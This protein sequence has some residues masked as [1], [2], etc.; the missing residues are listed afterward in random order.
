M[1]TTTGPTPG[2]TGAGDD[3]PGSP[4]R[5]RAPLT[6]AAAPAA[7]VPARV[8]G[9][10]TGRPLVHRAVGA[11]PAVVAHRGSSLAHPENTLPALEAARR[12]GASWVEVDL[13]RTADGVVLL[14]HDPAL[15]RTTDGRGDVAGTRWRDVRHLDAGTWHSDDHTGV[16]VPSFPQLLRWAVGAP[17]THLLLEMKG[18]WDTASAADAVAVVRRYGLASRTV[19]QSFQPATVAAVAAAAPEMA[20]GLLVSAEGVGELGPASEPGHAAAVADLVRRHG[21]SLVNPGDRLLAADPDLVARLQA[22]GVAVW[23]WTVDEPARWDALVRAGVDG[24][25]TNR[26]GALLQ[27]LAAGRAA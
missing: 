10:V 19:L 25:I 17:G 24:L 18:V 8:P 6:T 27:H 20:R 16:R 21:L 1:T 13:R 3:L 23:P 22:L 9:H 14:L 7:V 12:D 15:D 2:A 26:P 5:P 4:P 11:P